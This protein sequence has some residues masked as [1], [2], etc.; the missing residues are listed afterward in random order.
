MAE[1]SGGRRGKYHI[2]LI[3]EDAG[4][5]GIDFGDALVIMMTG[6]SDK[7]NVD[8]PVE[9]GK[10][11][12]HLYKYQ[13]VSGIV[14]AVL[15]KYATERAIVKKG[16]AAVYAF[17]SPQGGAGTSSAAAACALALSRAGIKPLYVSFEV[18]NSTELFFFD[19]AGAKQ[20][21]S[22]IFSMIATKE[23]VLATIDAI[24]NNDSR[25]V[26]FLKKFTLWT[27][28]A[29]IKPDEMKEFIEAAQASYGAKA[30][31][32][33]LGSAYSRFTD[34]AFDCADEIFVV[35]DVLGPWQNKLD[36]L[37]DKNADFAKYYQEKTNIVF[38]KSAGQESYPDL[39]AKK[40]VYVRNY[41]IRP[42][43]ELID[44]AAG[45]FMGSV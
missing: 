42:P 33:D 18:F 12:L 11:V 36:A 2:A 15:V 34:A 4:T 41:M 20:G 27:E 29:E 28:V 22:D 13:R 26:S 39:N 35:A 21:L 10:K 9:P 37:F 44:A 38:N 14:R 19:N 8:Y 45:D 30:V 32:L 16:S 25:G 43:S 7:N 17:Y 40:T 1:K 24:K 5:N 6:E 23:N 31:V 3:D